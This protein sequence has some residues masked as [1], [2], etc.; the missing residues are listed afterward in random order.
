MLFLLQSVDFLVV[1]FVMSVEDWMWTENC[2]LVMLLI[3]LEQRFDEN[4]LV[5]N[6]FIVESHTWRRHWS[7]LQ[8]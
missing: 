8:N 2:T 3:N 7:E 4:Y 1:K 6:F 5:V